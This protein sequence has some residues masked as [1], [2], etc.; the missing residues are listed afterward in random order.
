MIP[1][2]NI[3]QPG[4][5]ATQA[6]IAL[7]SGLQLLTPQYKKEY[8]LK[9]GQEDFT[10]WLSTYAGMEQVK[11][12]EYFW[13]ENRSKLMQGVYNE[14][15]VVAPAVGATVTLTL[16]AEFHFNNGTQTPIR[17]LETVR[18]S[19]SQIEGQILAIVDET[20]FAFQYTVRPKQSTQAFVSANSA[21]LLAGEGLQFAGY[22]DAGE[23]SNSIIAQQDLDV[24]YTNSITEMRETYSATDL[25]EMTQVFY[26]G[27]AGGAGAGMSGAQLAGPSF[28]T[29]K[30][31]TRSEQRYA[32]NCDGKLMFG[33]VVT[34]TGLASTNSL[35][36]Q[37]I[38]PKVLQDG[39]TVTY[40][41]GNL[42]IAKLHEITR[43]ADVNGCAK[44]C[45]WLQDIYQNQDFNDGIFAAFPAGAY[46]WGKNETSEEAM[47]TYGTQTMRIDGYMLSTKKYKRFNPEVEWGISPANPAYENFGMIC[48]LGTSPKYQAKGE[49]KVTNIKNITIMYQDAP[50]GG[51]YGN[52]IR[53][54]L[55]GGG[56]LNPTNGQMVDNVEFITYKGTRVSA[57]NQFILV[58]KP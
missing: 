45:L 55:H 17:P 1:T 32:N 58:Q 48:P 14:T 18:I 38:L 12:R 53:T 57:A 8:V 51:T 39:E 41:P 15:E 29:F 4:S 25:G 50:K 23:A 46:V 13:F 22:M 40:N 47:V 56:S 2:S 33:D 7:I 6:N 11:N 43:I 24:K 36:S 19:S 28:Y 52:G 34:N 35:G 20:P 31:L 16:P 10:G 3:L 27:I 26:D 42:D 44:E 21:N 30:N 5:I 54:W 9:Y 49:D 37:G